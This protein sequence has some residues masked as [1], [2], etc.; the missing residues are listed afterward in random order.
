MIPFYQAKEII[1]KNTEVL[2]TENIYFLDALHRVLADNVKSPVDLPHYNRSAMDGYAVIAQDI[3]DASKDKPAILTII[4]EIKTGSVS[5]NRVKNKTAIKIMTGGMIPEGA[6]TVVIKED[7]KQGGN[8]LFVLKSVPAQKNICFIGEDIKKGNIGLKKDTYI[9]SSHIALLSTIGVTAVPV[10]RKPKIAILTTGDELLNVE[11]QLEPGKVRDSNQYG[12]YSQVKESGGDPVILKS[13]KDTVNDLKEK[14]KK[15]LHYDILITSGG[16]SVGDYDFVDQ[17]FKELGVK[18]FF[19]KVA[20]KP[21]KPVIFGKK[22]RT[23]IFGLPGYPV[24]TM[25]SFYEFVQP[26]ILKMQNIEKKLWQEVEAI[27]KE[28]ISL[29]KGRRKILRTILEEHNGKL[30]VRLSTHQGSGNILSLAWANSLLEVDEETE[31]LPR[32][33]KIKVKMLP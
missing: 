2:D 19:S 8:T 13:A 14:V 24:S 11:D 20:I 28:D 15:A 30:F 3:K 31:F 23:L 25:I 32:G 29:K 33:M 21:G 26:S 4:D 7:T 17:V 5:R 6:D 16:A 10:Y 18:I 22:D 1:L 12:L 27:I 9:N